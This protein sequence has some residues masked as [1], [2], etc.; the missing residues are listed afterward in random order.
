MKTP[1]ILLLTLLLYACSSAPPG[2]SY[3]VLD[4]P[5]QPMSAINSNAATV[6][7]ASLTLPDYLRQDGLV[8]QLGPNQLHMSDR[9]YWAQ[10]MSAG[11]ESVLLKQ[12]NGDNASF[13][14]LSVTDPG[15][16]QS[17]YQ[18]HIQF[19]HLLIEQQNAVRLQA[20]YW[21]TGNDNPSP[22]LH[23]HSDI[24]LELTDDGY[25]HA[26][27]KMH[28]TLIRFSQQISEDLGT[29]ITENKTH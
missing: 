13:Q 20:S 8:M 10:S 11:I 24:S 2:I 14:L 3:Y 6:T 7:L 28:Q 26:V 16:L 27:A 15:V 21:L 9:H 12:L 17:Q 25:P 4:G 23:G 22:V 18:L 5:G 29:L 19:F 1:F